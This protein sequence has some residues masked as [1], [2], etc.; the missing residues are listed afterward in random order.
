M[1]SVSIHFAFIVAIAAVLISCGG[2]KGR[3]ANYQTAVCDTSHF[4]SLPSDGNMNGVVLKG[5]TPIAL[6]SITVWVE[7]PA[8]FFLD[9][10]SVQKSEPNRIYKGEKV[11]SLLDKAILCA[12]E[13]LGS[14]TIDLTDDHVSSSDDI[15][16]LFQPA[17]PQDKPLFAS[18]QS[19]PKG[20]FYAVAIGN[21]VSYSD[22]FGAP[23]N[24][25]FV[26][27]ATN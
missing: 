5:D 3:V 18:C 23:I 15:F 14:Y 7:N 8:P 10:K 17:S 21:S 24:P 25:I 6:K 11:R 22:M 16:I 2:N 19:K 20:M 12:P 9:I 1:K 13:Q 26:S 4:V 27:I